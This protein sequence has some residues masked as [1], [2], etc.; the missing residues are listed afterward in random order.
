MKEKIQA[1]LQ[2][3]CTNKDSKSISQILDRYK[4]KDQIDVLYNDG[5]YFHTAISHDNPSLIKILLDYMYDTKQINVDPKD[6]NTAQLIRYTELQ[7]V[8]RE[9]KKEYKT[10]S[11]IDSIIDDICYE[12]ADEKDSSSEQELGSIEDLI[13]FD[14]PRMN[15]NDQ[16]GDHY[17]NPNHD[18]PLIGDKLV[19]IH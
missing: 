12:Y 6:N 10:S 13:G 3:F 7:N 19:D 5:A 15:D 14:F 18:K 16:N 9:C 17:E 8:L 4:A 2:F 11:D 1:G